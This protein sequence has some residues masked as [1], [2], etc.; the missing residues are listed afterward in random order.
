MEQ[1]NIDASYKAPKKLSQHHGK[2]VYK[3]LQTATN[4]IG[5]IR[6]QALTGSD[7]HEQLDPALTAMSKTM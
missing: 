2:Q 5:Q 1:L 7:A 3:T 4:E 6:V